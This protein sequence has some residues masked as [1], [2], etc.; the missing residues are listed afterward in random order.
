MTGLTPQEI[1]DAI[2][3]GMERTWRH[4]DQKKAEQARLAPQPRRLRD[5]AERKEPDGRRSGRD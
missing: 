4:I 1:L 2:K 5:N 3:R